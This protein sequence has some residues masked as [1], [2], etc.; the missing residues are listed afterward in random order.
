MPRSPLYFF[1][2][3]KVQEIF[4][5]KKACTICITYSCTLKNACAIFMLCI[6]FTLVERGTCIEGEP[7][8]LRM[9]AGGRTRSQGSCRT[10]SAVVIMPLHSSSVLGATNGK[11]AAWHQQAAG[12]SV[13]ANSVL[14][15]SGQ[16][17]C[18]ML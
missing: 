8:P 17:K 18:S 11:A 6:E 9:P 2:W 13:L 1:P 4:S 5:E 12:F 10:I 16:L 7:Q 15:T 14:K 3:R